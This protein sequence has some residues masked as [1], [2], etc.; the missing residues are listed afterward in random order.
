MRAQEVRAAEHRVVEVGRDEHDAIELTGSH[1]SPV[2]HVGGGGHAGSIAD[3]PKPLAR[4]ARIWNTSM[5]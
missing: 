1:E 5:D 4:Y 3:R 2:P